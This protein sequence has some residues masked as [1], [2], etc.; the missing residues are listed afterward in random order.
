MLNRMIFPRD[1]PQQAHRIR[2][3]LIAAGASAVVLALL[4]L[5]S[6]L[7]VLP[8][9]VFLR[10]A[11]LMLVPALIFFAIFRMGINLR[12]RDGSLT[13]PQIFVSTLFILYVLYETPGAHLTL[14]LIFMM[15]FLFGVF[16]L[17]TRQLL[18]LTAFVSL[19]YAAIVAVQTYP[20]ADRGRLDQN[21]LHWAVLTTLLVFFSVMGGYVSGLRKK[22]KEANSGLEMALSR[23]EKLAGQDELTGVLNRRS[24]SEVLARQKARVD[25]YGGV[26]SML[27]IDLDYFKSINDTRGHAMGDAVLVQFAKAA[28]ACLRQCDTFGR[29]GGEEFLA[30]LDQTHVE[31]ACVLGSRIC[32]MA[33]QLQIDGFE[34]SMRMTVSV[35]VAQYRPREEWQAMIERADKALYRAKAG[36][37]DRI[38]REAEA[39]APVAGVTS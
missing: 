21:I 5:A 36:G 20:F 28:S 27:V 29:Y 31:G 2:R 6:L 17:S 15:S 37:R 13:L 39:Q 8:P 16:R 12:F 11:V 26:F 38:E 19:S 24:L 22:L 18:A 14:S 4:G 35:G 34:D 23:I 10:A 33:R 32:E 30:V 3:L 7:G 1:N 9:G 25:R